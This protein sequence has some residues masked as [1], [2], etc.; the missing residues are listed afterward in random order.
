ML[1]QYCYYFFNHWH[2][3]HSRVRAWCSCKNKK[4]NPQKITTCFR[5]FGPQLRAIIGNINI[6]ARNVRI[7]M[8]N[9]SVQFLPVLWYWLRRLSSKGKR[10]YYM[11]C[12]PAIHG[13]Y[14]MCHGSGPRKN[15]LLTWKVLYVLKFIKGLLHGW[16]VSNKWSWHLKNHT[17]KLPRLHGEKLNFLNHLLDTTA[18]QRSVLGLDGRR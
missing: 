18:G 15:Y 17:S 2:S 13:S 14:N 4:Q 5:E 3:S 16:L 10:W 7:Q 12:Q 11:D 1:G 6:L 9:L 8:A